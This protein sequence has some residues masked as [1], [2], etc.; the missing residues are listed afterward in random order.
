MIKQPI[1]FCDFDG[2]ITVKDN[3]VA[4]MRKFAPPEWESITE[5]ILNQEI[6]IRKG[7]GALFQLL[8][9]SLKEEITRFSIEQAEIRPGF[10]NLL[11]FAKKETIPYYVVSGGIDFF[12]DPIL[13]PFGLKK[14]Q[15]Y[16]N[17]S[18]F[19]G[20]RI[21][22]T[23][24]NPCDDHCDVDC[25]LCK[26]TIIRSY[27]NEKYF[28]IMIGDSITDLAGAKLADVVFARGFLLEKCKQLGLRYH[29]Y[30]TF[31]DILEVLKN[32]PWEYQS[33]WDELIEIKELFAGRD[34]FPG[35]SGN[36][37][38][39]VDSD[40]LRFLVT[41]SGKDKSKTTPEDFLLVD[42]ESKPTY[43]THLKPSAETM[44][45]AE[46]YKQMGEK[47]GAVFHVHTIYNNLV[48]DIYLQQE[49][50]EI[51]NIELIKAFN[52]WDEGAM[53]QVP[54]VQNYADIPKLTEEIGKVLDERVPG[55]LIHN[56]GIY[57]WGKNA[58]E[59]KR[60]LEAFE[61]LFEYV[62]KRMLI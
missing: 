33:T 15:I 10:E 50:V 39:K 46:I 57:A 43:P 13:A 59:A 11:S 16:R 4:I 55:V 44:I 49:N 56:H 19:S 18:D 48:S 54:I 42:G 36:L 52:I 53:I 17:E 32:K 38:I 25:G 30:E 23:W 7:V 20:E 35:T 12:V 58:F 51:G 6:S 22:I 3:I 45:H 21:K 28:K 60:H 2:T 29:P 31:D 9:T 62:Y 8:P 34:W 47:A 5:Q 41:A 14:S 40:P 26:T 27:P 24:P 61:F 1:I 37:S